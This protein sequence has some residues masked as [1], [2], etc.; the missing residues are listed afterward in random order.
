MRHT[1]ISTSG[2]PTLTILIV[3][4]GLLAS[5]CASNRPPADDGGAAIRAKVRS[6]AIA[7]PFSVTP[8]VEAEQVAAAFLGR[9]T[10]RLTTSGL[11]VVGPEIWDEIW[12]RYAG[13]VG[14]V[15]DA[16]TGEVDEEKWR[17]VEDATYRELVE[18]HSIDAIL[19]LMVRP[20][21][22]YGVAVHPEVCGGTAPPYWPGGW[23]KWGHGASMVRTACLIGLLE[24]P[25]GEVLFARHAPIEGLETFD[26]QTRAVRPREAVFQNAVV[27][28]E[29]TKIVLAPLLGPP[30]DA[31]KPTDRP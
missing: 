21:E 10:D 5:A 30:P 16:S 13:D 22:T 27:L 2:R 3:F 29:A 28:D 7:T 14:G 8:I 17:T 23:F 31:V 11:R 9:A 24:D 1:K 15:Y 6:V 4:L 19:Y 20:A 25:I 26:R 18:V 12:R